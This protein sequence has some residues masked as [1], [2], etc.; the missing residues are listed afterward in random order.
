MSRLASAVRGTPARR[1]SS[2]SLVIQGAQRLARI[3]TIVASA[4]L[5]DPA[6]FAAVAVTLALTDLVRAA[7]LAYDVSAVRL[8]A[9]GAEPA[10]VMG[11]HLGA[12][13]VIG[14]I[15]TV[16]IVAFSAAA[17]GPSTTT[18]VLVASVGVLP[19]GIAATL[20]VRRQVDFQLES[21]AVAVLAGSLLG[22]ATAIVGLLIS[23]QPLAVVAGL[24]LGDVAILA[25]L[26]PGLRIVQR[27][28]VREV[29]DVMRR[30]WT[31]LVMQLAY[32]GQFRVGTLVLGAAGTAVAVAEY[33]VA[34]R[35]AEGL[36]I[37]AAAITASSLPLMGGAIALHDTSAVRRLMGKSYRLS[38]LAAALPV[39]LLA[40]SAPAWIGI[41]FPR[42]QGAAAV[43]VPVGLTVV[44][45]FASS[46]TTAFLNASHRDRTAAASASIGLAVAIVGSWWLVALGALGVAV[47]RLGA[48]LVRLAIETAAIARVAA[49][50]TR[51]MGLA[52]IAI[53]PVLV[54]VVAPALLG[55]SVPVALAGGAIVLLIALAQAR[56]L[57][58]AGGGR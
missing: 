39:A 53:G 35:L 58:R 51:Q 36:V 12:K 20:M 10:E 38:L 56:S 55:W 26:A 16:A 52:W 37:L 24:V 33:T 6:P 30:T 2:G 50:L 13:V 46:Q 54:V 45:F 8:M 22:A 19:S 41:L 23:H 21:V 31:L 3:A 47:A 15:G 32:I 48:E 11:T 7:L 18:L 1:N 5:L 34:S 40:L 49:Y 14:A 4:A 44:I 9:A 42:Y 25:A 29:R 57:D 17:Y 27:V 28:D 43:F